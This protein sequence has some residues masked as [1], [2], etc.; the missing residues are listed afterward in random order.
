[1]T[2]RQ[3]DDLSDLNQHV[4]GESARLLRFDTRGAN[5]DI[6]CALAGQAKQSIDILTPDLE[7]P[8]YDN[9]SFLEALRQ[10]A[11]RSRF[12][13]V[14]VLIGD[15][16]AAVKSGHR[17][18][19]LARH[20]TSSVFLHNPSRQHRDFSHAYLLVDSAGYVHKKISSRYEGEAN[21][22]DRLRVR[23][24][25]REFDALWEQSQP[26]PEMRRLHI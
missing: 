12:T 23:D 5:C 9:P 18:I 16:T 15:S 25:L 26:D 7:L 2:E 21:F 3:F 11:I 24:L 6:A 20:F 1:M 14:R 4:L 10:L 8:V 22:S 13:Q 17:L 19:E